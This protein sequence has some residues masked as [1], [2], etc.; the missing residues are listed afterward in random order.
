MPSGG[1]EGLVIRKLL[2]AGLIVTACAVAR[3]YTDPEG[4][5][6]TG[7]FA[8]RTAASADSIRVVT[9]NIQLGLRIPE[10]IADL[11]ASPELRGADILLLQEL[12]PA[13]ADSLAR[14]LG[15]SYVYY[16]VSIHAKHGKDFGNAVLSKWP[17]RRYWKVILPHGDPVRDARRM[18]TAAEIEI[19]GRSVAVYSAHTALPWLAAEERS[20]QLDSLARWAARAPDCVIVG[21]DFNTE[22]SRAVARLEEILAGADLNRATAGIGSTRRADLPGLLDL[23]LDH[24]FVK[25]FRV[26]AR[27]KVETAAASDH[28]PVWVTLRFD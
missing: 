6:Y 14:S 1:A 15:Y 2:I 28:L 17:I 25:G 9:Y 13:G 27:G 8:G 16:P 3:N 18:A 26:T 23:E 10:A 20:A 21:G 5:V 4:P 12:D 22:T 24:I 7:D 19:G 11:T